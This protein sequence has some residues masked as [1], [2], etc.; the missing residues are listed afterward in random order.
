MVDR[1]P[2]ARS[3]Y[4]GVLTPPYSATGDGLP[5][6]NPH[7]RHT[8]PVAASMQ[9]F[10]KG[11]KV[12]GKAG[13]LFRSVGRGLDP[14]V[15]TSRKMPRDRAAEP[16]RLPAAD[17]SPGRGGFSSTTRQR[18]PFQGSWMRRRR[19]LRG[20]APF[21]CPKP[22]GQKSNRKSQPLDLPYP[23]RQHSGRQHP[24][25]TYASLAP[26]PD[27]KNKTRRARKRL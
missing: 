14:A 2:A 20:S 25:A 7:C 11:Q 26:R 10:L 18:L 21:R 13:R 1:G 22:S 5:S 6:H 23:R 9:S 24:R 3:Q 19:R 15:G 17:T 12:K 16:L 27:A 8:R 4:G